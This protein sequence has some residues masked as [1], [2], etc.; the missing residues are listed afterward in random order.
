MSETIQSVAPNQTA[1]SERELIAPLW[2]TFLL[3]L[4]IPGVSATS[5]F[6]TRRFVSS[7]RMPGEAR[8]ITS[9]LGAWAHSWGMSCIECDPLGA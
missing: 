7:G 2:H 6:L 3:V 4:L 9:R 1:P 8:L 5:Y